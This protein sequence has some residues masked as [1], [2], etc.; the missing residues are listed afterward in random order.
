VTAAPVRAGSSARSEDDRVGQ[1]VRSNPPVRGDDG[2]E[3]VSSTSVRSTPDRMRE[4]RRHPARGRMRILPRAA[5]MWKRARPQYAQERHPKASTCQNSLAGRKL[6]RR[7]AVKPLGLGGAFVLSGTREASPIEYSR[8]HEEPEPMTGREWY[9]GSVPVV[10][11]EVDSTSHQP[12]E[13]ASGIRGDRRQ[14]S[15]GKARAR[16]GQVQTGL[17]LR[18]ERESSLIRM[19]RLRAGKV[20]SREDSRYSW[21][22]DIRLS[23]IG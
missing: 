19:G 4:R 15:P 6:S 10:S 5:L 22:S 23:S 8:V 13:P 11:R 16:H 17:G 1:A 9:E 3:P 7:S 12:Y 2:R 20:G 18:S 21:T 14:P